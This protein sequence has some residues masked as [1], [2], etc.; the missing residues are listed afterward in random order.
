ML[1]QLQPGPLQHMDGQLQ[2]WLGHG[3]WGPGRQGPGESPLT[4]RKGGP[5]LSGSERVGPLGPRLR[6]LRQRGK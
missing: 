3:L 4:Q 2:A 1:I 5:C 6:R